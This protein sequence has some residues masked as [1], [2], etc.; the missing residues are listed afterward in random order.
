MNDVGMVVQVQVLI[1][2]WVLHLT[3]VGSG[4]FLHLWLEPESDPRE[5][6]FGCGFCFSPVGT[7]EQKKTRKK[8]KKS[9]TRKNSKPQR[10]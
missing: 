2:S 10:N 3:G 1:N 5:T 7:P 8:L 9:E 6:E 4:A